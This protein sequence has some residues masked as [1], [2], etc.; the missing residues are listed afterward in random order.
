MSINQ[1]TI[2]S[3]IMNRGSAISEAIQD[4][5]CHIFTVPFINGLIGYRIEVGRAVVF[6]D[7]I[8][9]EEQL[10]QLI[11]AFQDHCS[12]NNL[13]V[14]YFLVSESF[15]RWAQENNLCTL[16]I[17]MAE[18]LIYNPQR[19][20][21][22]GPGGNRLRNKVSHAQ[23][24]GLT[25]QEYLSFDPKIEKEMQHLG[26]KWQKSRKGPQIYLGKLNFFERRNGRRWFYV[27]EKDK[28]I[29]VAMLKRIESRQ[30]WL[31]KFL[32]S[33]PKATRGT[34]EWLMLFILETLRKEGCTFLTNGVLP[35]DQIG[36]AKGIQP[37]T[38]LFIKTFFRLSKW[39]FRLGQR[40]DY[41]HKFQPSVEKSYALFCKDTIGLKDMWAILQSF[42]ID[43]V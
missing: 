32:I 24:L 36:E 13:Q 42:K 21:T 11:Q 4:G 35:A 15:V 18:E 33:L 14:I 19:D 9:P 40:K 16:S 26:E 3:I 31:I 20:P 38:I 6:G 27:K 7:P 10:L 29:A 8:C 43:F 34:S 39:M 28:V 22:E 2:D 5:N 1:E 37:L 41:W 30:G 25:V 12:K 23:N 17:Q